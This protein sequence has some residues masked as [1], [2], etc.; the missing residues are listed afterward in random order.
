MSFQLKLDIAK[1]SVMV[2]SGNNIWFNISPNNCIQKV[3]FR[4]IFLMVDIPCLKSHYLVR[5]RHYCM[6]ITN[7]FFL[8]FFCSYN[9][10][11]CPL[12]SFLWNINV[13]DS[14][15]ILSMWMIMDQSKH[16][17]MPIHMYFQSNILRW[18]TTNKFNTITLFL[19]M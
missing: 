16:Y 4:D 17:L 15:K 3:E 18:S 9:I 8:S 12:I 14:F 10:L 6:N 11:H 19:I 5:L 13:K 1:Q 2:M 7:C